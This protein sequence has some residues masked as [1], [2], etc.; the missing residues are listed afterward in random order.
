MRKCVA[1]EIMD[2][3]VAPILADILLHVPWLAT[4]VIIEF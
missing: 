2:F 4:L 1:Q 3:L